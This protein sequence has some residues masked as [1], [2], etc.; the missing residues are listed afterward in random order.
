MSEEVLEDA[1]ATFRW[2]WKPNSCFCHKVPSSI[3]PSES[4]ERVSVISTWNLSI[5]EY[6]FPLVYLLSGNNLPIFIYFQDIQCH[7]FF[8]CPIVM[9]SSLPF[10]LP[11]FR[12]FVSLGSCWPYLAS[13]RSP[14]VS[15]SSSKL[16]FIPS[17]AME[18]IHSSFRE[19]SKHNANSICFHHGN[20]Y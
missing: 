11:F 1:S 8:L 7:H 15:S 17:R 13:L 14:N 5:Y 4:S 18:E 20:I 9:K 16:H 12:F 6:S 10:W 19:Q 2:P 3:W